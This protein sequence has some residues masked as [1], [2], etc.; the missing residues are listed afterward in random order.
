MEG[1][2]P[3]VAV[4]GLTKSYGAKCA[5]DDVSFDIP[6]GS[7]FALVG[8]NGAGKTTAI[9][10]LEG[11]RTADAGRLQV[12][13]LDPRRG[14]ASLKQR[15]G[16]ML[17]EAGLYLTIT[18][19]EALCLFASYYPAPRDPGELLA[20]VGLEDAAGTKY[21]RLSG[22]QKRRLALALALV[23]RP[24]LIFLDEPTTGMD[25]HAR[26]ATWEIVTSLRDSGTTVVLSTHYLEEAEVLADRVA[27]VD[28]GR[29]AALGSPAELMRSDA[30]TVKVRTGVPV[31][32]ELFAALPQ[33]VSVRSEEQTHVLQTHDA[34]E[35]LTELTRVLRDRNVPIVEIRVGGGSLEDVFL[36]LTGR[37]YPE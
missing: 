9:E 34:A 19:R 22:G 12:L 33:T 20:L 29:L 5:L 6:L 7:I 36:Q 10:I 8:P 31:D 4:S 32:S 14:A 3:A 27:I 35:L 26:R 17:Q 11:Y 21:R 28:A 2:T 30:S 18:P 25:P 23:G 37:E 13:G 15:V 1:A 24:E 16:V